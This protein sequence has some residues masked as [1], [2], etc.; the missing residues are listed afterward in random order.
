M[1][2]D[3]HCHLYAEEFD[4]D[5][6]E[7]VARALEAGADKILLPNFDANT[8]GPML[9]VC[10]EWH[11]L[12]HPM[13]GLHPT[14]LPPN[15]TPL[16]DQMERMLMVEGNPFIAIGEVGVD[17]YWDASRR[18]E[19][20]EVLRRQAEWSIRFQLPLV[21]HMRSA[22]DELLEV[23]SPLKDQLPGGIFHCFGGS[24]KEAED[25]LAFDRFYL[26]IAGRISQEGSHLGGTTQEDG[27]F[28][29]N[30]LDIFRFS[31][32]GVLFKI[33]VVL[34]S[35]AN[36]DGTVGEK[37]Q[38]FVPATNARGRNEFVCQKEH[39]IAR[40]DGG[41][42]VPFL[43]HRFTTAAHIGTIHHIIV[44]KGVI[45]IHLDADSR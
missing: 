15:P 38:G 24:A 22:H 44:H 43:M 28:E 8:V 35:F 25:L 31:D 3:T 23:L 17:L 27:G 7:V 34:L 37:A 6:A 21:I 42:V 29:T 5:R 14:E 41:V 26:G 33:D 9:A 10:D 2:I 12:C 18:A 19:Q 39:G 20:M 45:V 36:L 4:E 32:V 1:F 16:L 11:E 40:K 13:L 30:H